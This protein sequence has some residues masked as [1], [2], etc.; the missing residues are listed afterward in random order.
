VSLEQFPLVPAFA[1]TIHKIQGQTLT[2]A[3]IGSFRN[4]LSSIASFSAIYVALSRAR[5]LDQLL[6]LEKFDSAIVR[7]CSI[8]MHLLDELKRLEALE[9]RAATSL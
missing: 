3:I 9:N 1:I 5:R 2:R 8:P 6:L 7:R 4:N